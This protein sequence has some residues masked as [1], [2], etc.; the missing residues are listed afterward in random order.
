MRNRQ[1]DGSEEVMILEGQ[2]RKESKINLFRS[3][4]VFLL[5]Y[6][7][8]S[9]ISFML[10]YCGLLVFCVVKVMRVGGFIYEEPWDHV[11]C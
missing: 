4:I 5:S 7:I 11:R 6:H 1:T 2:K 3:C 10:I 8:I 9:N